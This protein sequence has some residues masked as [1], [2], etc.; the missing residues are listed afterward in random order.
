[1]GQWLSIVVMRATRLLLEKHADECDVPRQ[2]YGT[3]LLTSNARVRI[4]TQL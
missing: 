1:M 4:N 3:H 2:G